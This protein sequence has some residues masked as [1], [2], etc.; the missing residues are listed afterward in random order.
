M[1][2]T[3]VAELSYEAARD[4]LVET[5]HR[6]E[7]GGTVDLSLE[8]G[9]GRG[10][11]RVPLL[12]VAS[13]PEW[14]PTPEARFAMGAELE[15]SFIR[16]RDPANVAP[17]AGGGFWFGVESERNRFYL[18]QSAAYT[19]NPTSKASGHVALMAGAARKLGT[20]FRTSELNEILEK[21]VQ[22]HHPPAVQGKPRRFYY[23]TQLK[24]GPPTI[25][26]FS[27]VNE[28]LH[29]SYK[30]YLENQFRDAL[31]LTG[32]P[33]S[34]KSSLAFDT[35]YAEGQRRY[36]ETLS[37]YAR[38][39]L[40]QMEKPDVDSIE[41]LSPAISIEQKTTSKNPRS[42]VGTVTEIYDYLRVLFARIG[43]PACPKCGRV[44]AAQTVQQMVDR[45][46]TLPPG[47]RLYVLAPVVR[48]R[49]GEYRKVLFDLRQQGYS[50]VRVNGV[51]HE[52]TEEIPLERNRKHTI[53]QRCA[54]WLLMVH[55]RV[56]RDELEMTQLVLSQMLGVRRSSVT[57]AAEALRAAGARGRLR[58]RRD[59][60]FR[61]LLHQPVP[62]HPHQQAYRRLERQLRQ[63]DAPGGRDRAPHARSRRP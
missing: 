17:V 24:S 26:L 27:N 47:T 28:P 37:P 52:L 10:C 54:R 63:P 46:L 5:V 30:R 61:G 36:V 39:F 31:G 34:G 18:L 14:R 40:E 9:N 48:G 41:G 15:S 51:I 19:S 44:I 2:E 12:G 45:L 13:A 58:R 55:D 21:A 8:L 6:L 50:R 35:I 11:V 32:T 23:A 43:L 49:K 20:R 33:G 62:R 4:E 22:A 7:A 56:P 16:Y 53:V 38:Q 57:V 3:P 59:H 60:G 42:T 29:F 25:A 1:P